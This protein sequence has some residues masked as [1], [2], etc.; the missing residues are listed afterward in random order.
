MKVVYMLC[1]Y[2][3][4]PIAALSKQ[5]GQLLEIFPINLIEPCRL[6]TINIDDGDCLTHIVLELSHSGGIEHT[7][8]SKRIG[9]TISLRLSASQA[10]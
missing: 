1:L 2:G 3:I 6:C 5:R 10:I 4:L 9:T 8:P 7:S